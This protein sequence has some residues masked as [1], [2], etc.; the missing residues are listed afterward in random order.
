VAVAAS[1]AVH[2]AVVGAWVVSERRVP[3]EVGQGAPV[4]ELQRM[5]VTLRSERPPAAGSATAEGSAPTVEP[6]V[7]VAAPPP[8]HRGAASALPAGPSAA[9][10]SA[11]AAVPSPAVSAPSMTPRVP[12]ATAPE[13]SLAA[14]P[15][16][17]PPPSTGSGVTDASPTQAPVGVATH[18]REG[19]GPPN[20]PG[21]LNGS[22]TGTRPLPDLGAL[23]QRLADSARRCYPPA[24]A[25][26]RLSGEAE[27]SF[28]VLPGGA[29]VRGLSLSRST[30]QPLL[31][32]AAS[33]CVV[34]GALPLPVGEGCYRVPVRFSVR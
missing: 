17:A 8:E 9:A 28:C 33:E 26:L 3:D 6:K 24:A 34:P 30:Q 31:D 32:R 22:P 25:R 14:L 27:L 10:A 4:R 19:G 18:P 15:P 20:G 23:H 12:L 21:A 29:S 2:V 13:P 5:P 1:I 11:P 7:A 16:P